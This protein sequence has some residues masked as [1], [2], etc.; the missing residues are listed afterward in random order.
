VMAGRR[1]SV[2]EV[3][4]QE[5]RL[6]GVPLNANAAAAVAVA[7]A[8]AGSGGPTTAAANKNGSNAANNNP[9]SSIAAAHAQ[10]SVQNE[11]LNDK[12]VAVI[13]RVESKLKGT[14]FMEADG[15]AVRMQ[16]QAGGAGGAAAGSAAQQ[17]GTVLDVSGQVQRLIVEATSHIN[18]C[19]SYIG[20]CPFW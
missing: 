17:H 12:A 4:T 15:P 1:R 10:I 16:Q 9:A 2:V 7:Q 18:L 20:W 11:Q 8:T 3:E 14:D 5:D 19:Q 13:S 6:R